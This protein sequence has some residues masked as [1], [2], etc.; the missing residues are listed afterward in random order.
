MGALL[1]PK[2]YS[3]QNDCQ[4]MGKWALFCFVLFGK[5]IKCWS[6]YK[7][8]AYIFPYTI[9]GLNSPSFP[10][11]Y[12]YSTETETANHANWS[13][14]GKEQTKLFKQYISIVLIKK[15]TTLRQEI[16]AAF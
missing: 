1:C 5:F 8:S 10:K 7:S 11:K 4:K 12:L 16:F 14:T 13:R 2:L 15:F 9:T 3:Q 6:Y